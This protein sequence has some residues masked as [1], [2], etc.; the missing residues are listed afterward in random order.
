MFDD[1]LIDGRAMAGTWAL[2]QV[3]YVDGGKYESRSQFQKGTKKIA[4][5]VGWVY[6]R[7]GYDEND[8]VE[9]TLN[10]A[11]KGIKNR[12]RS[13]PVDGIYSILGL[14]SYGNDERIIIDY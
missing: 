4:T 5:P 1:K 10:Q 2:N 8:K 9:M 13:V 12:G 14:L 11:L 3:S 7:D 6:Y